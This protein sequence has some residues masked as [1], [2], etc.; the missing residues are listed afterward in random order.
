[1]ETRNVFVVNRCVVGSNY[2]IKRDL[3]ENT[4]FKSIIGRVGRLFWLLAGESIF[5]SGFTHFT[6]AFRS[7]P[8]P[9]SMLE[10]S[11][12]IAV[13]SSV[14][15]GLS[16]WFSCVLFHGPYTTGYPHHYQATGLTQ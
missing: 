11:L 14:F 7:P 13:V 2:A 6:P 4:G 1:M 15:L 5:C 16:F 8:F 12:P 3:R 10:C 9:A